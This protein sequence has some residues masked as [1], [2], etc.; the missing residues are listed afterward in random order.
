MILVEANGRPIEIWCGIM[1]LGC[2]FEVYLIQTIES[3][4]VTFVATF[5]CVSMVAMSN[6]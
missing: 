3:H 6:K 5:Q 1:Y 2:V 4:E